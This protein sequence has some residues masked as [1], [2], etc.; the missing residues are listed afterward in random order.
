MPHLPRGGIW[1]QRRV[2][3]PASPQLIDRN[4]RSESPAINAP[5][6]EMYGDQ[7]KAWLPNGGELIGLPAD[8]PATM[9]KMLKSVGEDVSR[10]NPA[11]HEAFEVVADAARRTQQTPS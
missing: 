10:S 1:R 9:M 6:L 7:R 2:P 4:G 3:L 5:A 8:E 11:L